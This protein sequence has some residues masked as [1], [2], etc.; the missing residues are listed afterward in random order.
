LR[1]YENCANLMRKA[2]YYD[3]FDKLNLAPLNRRTNARLLV[4]VSIFS[5]QKYLP[6]INFRI[7]R[8]KKSVGVLFFQIN[9]GARQR[10][11]SKKKRF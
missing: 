4:L 10:D 9:S 5:Y 1:V 7:P 3:L 2:C 6:T 8:V 11:A